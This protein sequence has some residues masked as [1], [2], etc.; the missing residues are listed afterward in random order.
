MIIGWMTRTVEN[1]TTA[2]HRSQLGAGNIIVEYV[3]KYSAVAAP[4][5]SLKEPGSALIILFVYVI[6]A[7]R[8]SRGKRTTLM[9]TIGGAYSVP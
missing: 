6:S 4:R 5:I 3:V 7:W 8:S 9:K 2:S 1:V